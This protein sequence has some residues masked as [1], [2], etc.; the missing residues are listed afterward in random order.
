MM[1]LS[2]HLHPLLIDV[3]EVWCRGAYPHNQWKKRPQQLQWGK[4]PK[5]KPPLRIYEKKTKT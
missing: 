2:I 4:T 5:M 1:P 3:P